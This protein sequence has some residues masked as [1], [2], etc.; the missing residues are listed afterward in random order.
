MLAKS[1]KIKTVHGVKERFRNVN[2]ENKDGCGSYKVLHITD[3]NG[4]H[5]FSVSI[6]DLDSFSFKRMKGS[7][8]IYG[9]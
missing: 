5:L 8:S 2:L 4:E 9:D 3:L 6:E 1:V 7:E